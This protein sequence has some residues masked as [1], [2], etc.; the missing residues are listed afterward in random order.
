MCQGFPAPRCS[1]HAWNM[2]TDAEAAVNNAATFE[3]K[4]V[5]FRKLKKAEKAFFMT[6]AGFIWL[7]EKIKE[8]KNVLKKDA[9]YAELFNGKK[10]R[11]DS[12]QLGKQIARQNKLRLDRV[13]EM[14]QLSIPLWSIAGQLNVEF[15]EEKGFTVEHKIDTKNKIFMLNVDGEK[16]LS[17]SNKHYVDLG[18]IGFKDNSF[19][20]NHPLYDIVKT[21]NKRGSN[22]PVD[23]DELTG[24]QKETLIKTVIEKFMNEGFSKVIFCNPSLAYSEVIHLEDVEKFYDF[25]FL[26]PKTSK[27]GTDP[28]P[29]KDVSEFMREALKKYNIVGKPVK[30]EGKTMIEL[31]HEL[32]NPYD[33]YVG[34]K[35]IISHVKD[36][37]YVVRKLGKVNKHFIRVLLTVK[38]SRF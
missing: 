36:G 4:E 24:K 22:V 25:T 14:K 19:D 9:L 2:Y 21:F 11:R 3:E 38:D 33:V 10:R 35:F 5:A 26:T 20:D 28:I 27:T 16:L 32:D 8:T 1:R 29:D 18:V 30:V 34:D 12:I 37:F 23:F 17:L 7:E 6:P 15:L 31:E 13:K